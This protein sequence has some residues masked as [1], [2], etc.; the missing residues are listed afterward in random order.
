MRKNV[1]LCKLDTHTGFSGKESLAR[2][3]ELQ[4]ERLR[5]HEGHE[6]EFGDDEALMD[7]EHPMW[8]SERITLN[9]VGLDIGSSTSQLI[10]SRFTLR[11]QGVA[12]SSR[13]VVINREILPEG[14]QKLTHKEPASGDYSDRVVAGS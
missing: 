9:S 1:V 6:D 11:R 5:F 10:F 3:E 4:A 2:M 13:I 8:R 14:R 12:L 7:E